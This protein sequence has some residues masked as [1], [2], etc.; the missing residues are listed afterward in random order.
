MRRSTTV[1]LS[2]NISPALRAW[3]IDTGSLTARLIAAS[4]N[5]FQVQVMVQQWCKPAHQEAKKLAAPLQHRAIVREVLLLGKDQPW[6]F[7]R[8]IIPLT[9]LTGRLRAL[10]HLDNRPLGALLFRDK[11]LQRSPIEIFAHHMQNGHW[12]TSVVDRQHHH[13]Q[14]L[15]GRRSIFRLDNKPLIVGEVFLPSLTHFIENNR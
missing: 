13:G 14:P 9:T 10:R 11:T 6:V 8:S 15:F 3:L 4:G 1:S 12:L 2:T 7:A 5:R